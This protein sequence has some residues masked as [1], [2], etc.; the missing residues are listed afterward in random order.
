MTENDHGALDGLT[1]DDHTQYILAAGTRAL[2]ANW[3]AGSFQIRAET[4]QS[5]IVTGTAPFTVASTTVVTNL[6]ADLLDG[7]SSAAFATAAHTHVIADIT[8]WGA[9]VATFLATPSSA[10]LA[11]AVTGETGTGA[12]VFAES[13]TLTTPTISGAVTFP[14]NVTQVFNPG[15]DNAGVNV[16][17]IAG[18]PATPDNG[19]MWYDST[20]N[21]L[22]ARING[23]NVALGAGGGSNALLD[24]TNHTDTVAQAVTR[25]SII[26]GNST[27]AWDE[28][29]VGAA[30]KFL[31]ADGTD[32]AYK[33][34]GAVQLA[35]ATASASAT[36]DFTL[37]SPANSD[38]AAYLVELA[39]VAPASDAVE[40][41]LRTSTD[42]GST[43]E[44]SAGNYRHGSFQ[45]NS[46]G[47]A[48]GGSTSD[49][50]I[51]LVA[52]QGNAANEHL[53]LW[54]VLH[55]PSAAQYGTIHWNGFATDATGV[56]I[57][58]IGAGQRIAAADVDA[59][60]FLFSTGN[61]ASGEFRLY[62]IPNAA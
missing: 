56:L 7:L 28:L 61:I 42:G 48:V 52:N 1:D 58:R 14:D 16:G 40:L 60:R 43:Y 18:D 50:E 19:D 44:S 4:F 35:T 26:Y 30:H 54:L 51:A 9:N 46:S 27:S 6:N 57:G 17:S 3:D 32:V 12:L 39:H 11:A 23:V 5:D 38:F 2:T 49:T 24:G 34:P 47:S 53:S 29:V 15:A 10:N 36:V 31:R 13:P 55:R 8:N 62:G 22:T 25:G 41:W 21:E 20:A 59:I 37:T 45:F 33:Y